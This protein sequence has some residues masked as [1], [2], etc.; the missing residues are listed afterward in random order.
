MYLKQST[1]ATI[2]VGPILDSAGVEYDSAVIGD[3]SIRKHDGSVAAM[4][5]A[6]TLTL[7]A[8]GVYTLVMTT[9]NTDTI[10]RLQIHCNKA[11]YQM[12]VVD[13]NV[14]HSNVYDVKYG[15]VALATTTNITAGT[16]ATVSGSVGSLVGHTVQSGDTYAL[17]SG[18]TGFAAIDTVVD[19]IL[20]DTA[21]IGIAGAGLTNI[22]LP[23]QTMNVIGNITGN[24]SG[25]VG[26]VTNANAI[27]DAVLN[28]GASNIESTAD[29]HSLGAVVMLSTNAS[30][31]GATMTAKKPSDDSTFNTY[32]LTV[33]TGHITGVS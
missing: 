9:G 32:V 12:P 3:L 15:S 5:A 23:D 33:T 21:E 17:A 27:A 25:S 28:R 20:V 8:N 14:L 2:T 18:A 11:T 7:S 16:I 6:A 31:D 19:A 24:L 13:A 29:K 1:A 4:A 10:G 22:N 30:H 26:S